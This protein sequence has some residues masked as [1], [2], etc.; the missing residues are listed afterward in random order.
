MYTI[1]TLLANTSTKTQNTYDKD[2]S[3]SSQQ[4]SLYFEETSQIGL[5]STILISFENSLLS[6]EAKS[7]R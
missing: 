1:Q 6:N 4:L 7:F 5:V 3:Y 2:F